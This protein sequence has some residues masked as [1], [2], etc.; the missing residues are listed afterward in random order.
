M[1]SWYSNVSK[2]ESYDLEVKCPLCKSWNCYSS[3]PPTI[4][5]NTKDGILECVNCRKFFYFDSK[6]EVE[7]N[8]NE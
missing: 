5:G 3:H 6:L 8:I 2:D 1:S 4:E 7:M